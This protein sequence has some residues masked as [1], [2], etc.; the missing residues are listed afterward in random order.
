MRVVDSGARGRTLRPAATLFTATALAG[1]AAY[2]L[3]GLAAAQL[4]PYGYAPVAVFLSVLYLVITAMSGLQQE[5]ARATSRREPARPDGPPIVRNI[6][7]LAGVGVSGLLAATAWVWQGRVFEVSGWEYVAPLVVGASG[8]AFL[9]AL[10]GVLYGLELWRALAALIAGDA[11]L[12]LGLTWV[13]LSV[14]STGSAIAWAVVAP[15][16]IVPAAAWV[17]LRN[18]VRGA[19][20]VDVPLR[21]LAA[22]VGRTVLAGVAIGL[23]VSGLPAL[24]AATSAGAEPRRVSTAILAINLAR[25]PLIVVALSFQSF[26]VVR[27]RSFAPTARSLWVF[28]GGVA[29][30]TAGLALAGSL[31][32]GQIFARAF[33][34]DYALEAWLLG[35]IAGSGVLLAAMVV[36]GALALA[37]GR[38][39]VYAIGW[40]AAAAALFVT[41]ALPL[42]WGQRVAFAVFAGPAIGLAAHALGLR[43]RWYRPMTSR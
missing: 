15:F 17:V 4:G 16:A 23:L 42:E 8:Y 6:S 36:T 11:L 41:L 43:G 39:S 12:R 26:F 31:W 5:V 14:S 33:G 29:L 32:A 20:D 28:V 19:F 2:A 30:A 10:S 1:S 7:I 22:N 9:A 24:V 21:A 13:C 34:P 40:V 3:T 18:R 27:L 37:L 38:H 35:A 25:A